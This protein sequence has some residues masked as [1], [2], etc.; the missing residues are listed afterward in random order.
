MH[1]AV[2]SEHINEYKEFLVDIYEAEFCLVDAP[3]GSDTMYRFVLYHRDGS[4]ITKYASP[5]SLV[6]FNKY[7]KSC[8]DMDD[9]DAYMNACEKIAEK[10]ASTVGTDDYSWGSSLDDPS[11]VKFT[12]HV[13]MGDTVV[14]SCRKDSVFIKN[15]TRGVKKIAADASA[16]AED[17]R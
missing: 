10:L 13:A 14:L 17:R 6:H 16:T 12:V 8:S 2:T 1:D 4:A 3:T 9:R 11:V 15:M 5:Y 7:R